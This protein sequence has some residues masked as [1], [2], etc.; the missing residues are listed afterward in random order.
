MPTLSAATL[1]TYA[2]SLFEAAGVPPE[3]AAVVARS[4]VDANLCGHDSHGVMRVPQ[5]IDFLRKGTYQ[6]GVPLTVLNETPA[7]IAADGNWGLGQ[8][9]AYRLLDKL[10]PK[11]K[12]LGIAAGTLRQCGHAGRLGEY[13]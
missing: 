6:A 8:V 12:Q 13:A 10:L 9:Q 5:Y 3:D 11:A 2:R 7:V 4:L 1:T